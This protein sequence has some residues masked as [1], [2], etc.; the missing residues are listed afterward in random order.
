MSQ[1]PMLDAL[2]RSWR[3]RSPPTD[4]DTLEH[5]I[6]T[7]QKCEGNDEAALILEELLVIGASNDL[8]RAVPQSR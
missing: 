1:T 6:S 7:L 2:K 3:I 5:C 4:A 8:R